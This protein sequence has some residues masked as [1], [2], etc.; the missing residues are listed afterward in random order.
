MD[1]LEEKFFC[2][3]KKKFF[4]ISVWPIKEISLWPQIS[5]PTR[6]RIQGGGSSESDGRTEEDG[7]LGV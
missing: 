5:S 7:N 4:F 2:P 1:I 6:F 3:K